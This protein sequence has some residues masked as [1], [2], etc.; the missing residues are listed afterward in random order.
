MQICS[1]QICAGTQAPEKTRNNYI[2]GVLIPAIHAGM[3]VAEASL[4]S[5]NCLHVMLTLLR[6]AITNEMNTFSMKR[7]NIVLLQVKQSVIIA[8]LF[9]S[10]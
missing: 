2:H 7:N 1:R 10:H 9:A 6:P 3:T 4:Y 8:W 5:G